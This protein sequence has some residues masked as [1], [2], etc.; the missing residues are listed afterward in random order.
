MYC[1]FKT[2][3]GRSLYFCL[4]RWVAVDIGFVVEASNNVSPKM[5]RDLK[6]IVKRTVDRYHVA[7]RSANVGM[8]TYGNIA[9]MVFDFNDRILNNYEV[10]RVVDKASL[11]RGTPRLDRGLLMASRF[12]FTEERGMR[13]WVPKVRSV[14]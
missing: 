1:V 11:V 3:Y 7:P 5:W 6:D 14:L 4:D 10:K 12:L 13:R 9:T 2:T 8:I